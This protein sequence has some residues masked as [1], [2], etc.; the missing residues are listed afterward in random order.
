M[1]VDAVAVSMWLW[2]VSGVYLWW[3]RT[4]KPVLGVVCLVAGLLS[5]A[6]LVVLFCM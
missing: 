3:R 2:P 1:I 4:R 5:F 6:G